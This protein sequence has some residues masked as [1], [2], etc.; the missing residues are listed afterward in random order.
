MSTPEQGLEGEREGKRNR[1]REV[2]AW[3]RTC[4]GPVASNAKGCSYTGRQ[5]GP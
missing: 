1:E 2:K 5:G 4:A 3:T